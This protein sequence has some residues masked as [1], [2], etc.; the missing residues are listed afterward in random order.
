M[1]VLDWNTTSQYIYRKL[2]WTEK[3]SWKNFK[4]CFL[5]KKSTETCISKIPYFLSKKFH[6]IVI[7]LANFR[8]CDTKF[9]FSQIFRHRHC[10]MKI[11][12]HLSKFSTLWDEIVFH[13]TI[14]STST[15]WDKNCNSPVKIFDTVRQ[16]CNSSLR[17]FDI[18]TEKQNCDPLA[19]T[20][21]SVLWRTSNFKRENLCKVDPRCGSIFVQWVFIMRHTSVL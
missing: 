10:E 14:F 4:T 20:K 3:H 1:V 17:Y 16:N 2:P 19:P 18:D 8:H 21:F 6:T 13:L 5:S 7:H 11:V 12:I 15:L 9:Y